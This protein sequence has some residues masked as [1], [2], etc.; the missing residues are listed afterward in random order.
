MFGAGC[1]EVSESTSYRKVGYH[2]YQAGGRNYRDRSCSF[3]KKMFHGAN[4]CPENLNKS[5]KFQRCVKIGYGV[6]AFWALVRP[7]TE[8][9]NVGLE[10]D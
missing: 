7:N 5:K 3:C 9:V 2:Q 10:L 1:E 8:G 6:E 4:R